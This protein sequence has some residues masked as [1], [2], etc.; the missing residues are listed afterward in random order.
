MLLRLTVL[1]VYVTTQA[2]GL[3]ASARLHQ[4]NALQ[5]TSELRVAKADSARLSL[6]EADAP[7]LSLTEADAA[8][9]ARDADRFFDAIDTDSDGVLSRAELEQ[10]IGASMTPPAVARL[11]ES[12]DK[13]SDG[14]ISRAEFQ[15]GFTLS[16]SVG[17]R[18][19]LGLP[20]HCQPDRTAS[21]AEDARL[22]LADEVFAAIKGCDSNGEISS[23][24]LREHLERMANYSLRTIDSIMQVLD[25]NQDGKLDRDEMRAAF[26]R[27]EY[28][29]LRLALGI[30]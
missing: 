13:N 25:V 12:L 2:N 6:T 8:V 29:A 9:A 5:Y 26:Q 20:Q 4:R 19:A 23:R 15:R 17:L 28:A 14:V 1:I 3:I 7:R 24:E 22:A 27:Y 11:F 16:E 10:R 30:S 21:P 18:L